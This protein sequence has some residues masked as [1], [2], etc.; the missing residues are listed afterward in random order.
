M[1]GVQVSGHVLQQE[2]SE[3][4]AERNGATLAP[5]EATKNRTRSCC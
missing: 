5:P 1:Q 2:K 4:C 3:D